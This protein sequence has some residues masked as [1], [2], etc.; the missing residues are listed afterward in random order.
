MEVDYQVCDYWD[1]DNE[2]LFPSLF[3]YHFDDKLQRTCEGTPTILLLN[4]IPPQVAETVD[5]CCE[6]FFSYWT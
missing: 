1:M 4:S 6:R 2:T 3:L 5:G